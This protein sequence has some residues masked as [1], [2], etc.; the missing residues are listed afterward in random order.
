MSFSSYF[1]DV[2]FLMILTAGVMLLATVQSALVALFSNA[3]IFYGSFSLVCLFVAGYQLANAYSLGAS[4]Q[5]QAV[6]GIKWQTAMAIGFMPFTFLFVASF[7]QQHRIWPWFAM[8]FGVALALL[9]INAS[10]P[11]GL[12]YDSIRTF[13]HVASEGGQP[14]A[15]LQGQQGVMGILF[16]LMNGLLMAWILARV[17]IA[18]RREPSARLVIF[19]GYCC[20][21]ILAMVHGALIDTTAIPGFYTAGFSL[22]L[23]ALLMSVCLYLEYRHKVRLLDQ[24][25]EVLA[26]EV[27]KRSEAESTSDKWQQVFDR[28]SIA[29]AVFDTQGHLISCN[30]AYDQFW[31]AYIDGYQGGGPI[32]DAMQLKESAVASGQPETSTISRVVRLQAGEQLFGYAITKSA[33]IRCDVSRNFDSAGNVTEILLSHRDVTQK[34]NTVLAM[35]KI[36]KVGSSTTDQEFFESLVTNLA[37]VFQTRYAFIGRIKHS[38]SPQRSIETLSVCLDQN[39]IDNF[40]Y[41][42]KGTPCEQVFGLTV[43]CFPERVQSLFPDDHLLREMGIEGYVGAPIFDGAGVPVGILVVLDDKPI[44]LID[45]YAHILDIF[46]ARAGAELERLSAE[47]RV[48]QMA[49]EDYLTRLPNRAQMHEELKRR[50]Q[51][52]AAIRQNAAVYLLDLDNFKT[53]NDGLGHDVGDEVIRNVGARLRAALPED[54]F[55]A[56]MGGDEFIVLDSAGAVDLASAQVTANRLLGLIMEPVQIGERIL[57]IGASIGVV[58]F[59]DALPTDTPTNLDL[60]RYADMALYQAK[61]SGRNNYVIFESAL[62]AAVNERLEIERGLRAALVEEQLQI[63]VQPQMNHLGETV[64][65]EVLLRWLHPQEGMIPPS[66]FIPVA[67]ETGL[68]LKLGDWVLEQSLQYLKRWESEGL[69]FPGRLSVNISAWQFAQQHFVE[70]LRE[71]LLQH[72]VAPQLITLELTET[73]LLSDINE[74]KHKL[75]DLRKLG[76]KVSLDDFGTGYSS[77]AYLRVLPL[78]GFKIDKA[79]VD[80]VRA[81]EAQ[82]LIESM[83]AI[84]RHMGL[85][86]VAEGVET[87]AQQQQLAVMGCE[88][89]QGY[90]FAKPMPADAFIAWYQQAAIGLNVS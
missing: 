75:A 58:L 40:N 83:I 51:A 73:A 39:I 15:V 54:Y 36:A 50:L 72:G 25:T 55:I 33:W 53:V 61:N 31:Q 2:I 81:G 44:T 87:P 22:T 76:F 74:A 69:A 38:D 35:E 48:R 65:A 56:R 46:T 10:A 59:P 57:S 42:L 20:F 85:D 68:I 16:H 78:D 5:A 64:G 13:S 62:Q 30:A 41:P 21:H 70:N 12:R 47:H 88:F 32:F 90:L 17:V 29:V 4:S 27:F 71:L 19:G 37:L 26:Q 14:L 6:A 52:C 77:L 66:R 60:L 80:E 49:Y 63:F 23:L 45:N 1:P 8:V 9:L 89:F 43:C 3:R 11:F 82:P 28:A 84:G 67:E 86:V 24:S 7:T 34:E 18:F 79:F